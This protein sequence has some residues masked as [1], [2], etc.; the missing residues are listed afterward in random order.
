MSKADTLQGYWELPCHWRSLTCSF[1]DLGNTSSDWSLTTPLSLVSI[2][3]FSCWGHFTPLSDLL[4]G[5][6]LKIIQL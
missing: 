6:P 4:R 5:D 3:P 1:L 2:S